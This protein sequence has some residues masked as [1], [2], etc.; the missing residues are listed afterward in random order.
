MDRVAIIGTGLIGGSIGLA[1]KGGKVTGL[2][3]IGFD[4]DRS[5]LNEAKKRG[6]V[7]RTAGN[8]REA[9]SG[10]RLVIVAA[11]PLAVRQV[12]EDI[13]P[14]L[15]EGAI[16]TDTA[17]TKALPARWAG[18]YLPA[19]VSYVGGHPMAGK[20]QQGIKNAEAGLFQGK[21]WAVVP[22]A[23]ANEAAVQ[24]VIGLITIAGAEALFVDADEHDQYVAA[25]SHLPLMMS[26]A[27]FSLVR[28]SPSWDDIAP[29]A[30]S[31]FKDMTRL[32]SGDP[33]MAHDIMATNVDAVGHWI[34]R[35]IVELQRL[36]DLMQ[37]N[38]KSLFRQFSETQLQRDAFV[39]GDWKKRQPLA[40][41]PSAKDA[42]S[43]MLLGGLLSS[44]VEKF[45][46]DME[47][48]SRG[49][50]GVLDDDED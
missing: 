7:D 40:E 42:M 30:A 26:A 11:P 5:S 25:I 32:A 20:E 37:E 4:D 9:V 15:S 43:S 39:A 16:V 50:R 8:L 47:R 12:F 48:G 33:R 49:R 13:G 17:S 41:A 46:K 2:E 31:G 23:R 21:T 28:Q 34:D 27:L 18:E 35:F 3:V 14:H 29:L 44:R 10:A 6:A 45:E 22:S 19:G 36:R 38:R 1:L 24:S